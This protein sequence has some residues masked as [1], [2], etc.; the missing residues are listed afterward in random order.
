MRMV[1]PLV[2]PRRIA[3]AGNAPGCVGS[4]DDARRVSPSPATHPRPTDDGVARRPLID[5]NGLSSQGLADLGFRGGEESAAWGAA[6]FELPS[7]LAPP[8][9]PGTSDSTAAPPLRSGER[10]AAFFSLPQRT[11]TVN[12]CPC[13]KSCS[14]WW[15]PN[16]HASVFA[17]ASPGAN[18]IQA[19]SARWPRPSREV[20]LMRCSEIPLFE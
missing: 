1:L 16:M 18:S 13:W 15:R 7:I 6:P 3:A 10:Y 11:Q 9:P 2:L 12:D 14:H 20:V 17:I 5:R 4:P 8:E 19:Q